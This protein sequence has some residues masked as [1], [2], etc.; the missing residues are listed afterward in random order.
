MPE[1][2]Q[3]AGGS[4]LDFNRIEEW[5]EH[6]GLLKGLGMFSSADWINEMVGRAVSGSL[7]K[8]PSAMNGKMRPSEKQPDVFETHRFVIVKFQLARDTDF[9]AIRVF[10][11]P[12]RVKLSGMPEGDLNTDLPRLVV[13]SSARA[14][15]SSGV[16]QIKIKK[17]R[18]DTGYVEVGIRF[19]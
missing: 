17:R 19:E 2:D 15:Y 14:L 10:V 3:K 4:P 16:L 13:P 9:S 7:P 6:Q 1:K 12:D 11:R 18:M 8:K 5:L